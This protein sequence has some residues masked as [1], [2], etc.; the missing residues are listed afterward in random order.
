MIEPERDSKTLLIAF[1]QRARSL[2]LSE[3][4]V[5]TAGA[6]PY[7]LHVVPTGQR[8]RCSTREASHGS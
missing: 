3:T 1:G 8:S 7:S 6:D 2:A 4:V 5:T